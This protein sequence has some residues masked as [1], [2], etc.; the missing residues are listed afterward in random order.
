M[1]GNLGQQIGDPAAGTEPLRTAGRERINRDFEGVNQGLA[2]RF[3]G[4]QG[5][6]NSGKFGQASRQA[7]LARGQSLAGFESDFANLI[8][9]RQDRGADLA[10]R[11]LA[12]G[13]GQ[14]NT[15]VFSQQGSGTNVGAGLGP[16]E[17]GLGAGLQTA[18]TLLAL[19][20]LLR[21]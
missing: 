21:N 3:L 10:T 13:R 5:G 2:D 15:G 14:E 6:G 19:D 4:F 11:L 9:Q 8:L 12:L 17:G 16:L 20:Q 18:T 7:E 1:L